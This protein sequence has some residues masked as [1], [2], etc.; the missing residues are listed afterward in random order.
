MITK[1]VAKTFAE[2]LGIALLLVPIAAFAVD[3]SPLT[4]EDAIAQA[5]REAPQITA[6]AAAFDAATAKAP[7]A[8]R[9]PDP[10][11]VA[12][13]DNL[14][15]NTADRFS[16]TRDFMTMRR[17]GVMQSFPNRAKRRL[18]STY[19]QQ[20]VLVA[21]AELRKTRFE[22]ARAA[23]EAWIASA[24]AEESLAR[25]R[26]LQ[27]DVE[28][29]ASAAR[30]ALASGR[31]SSA[32]ALAAQAVGARLDDRILTLEQ[33]A[34]MR[35]AELARWV[36]DGA[37]RPLAP[38]PTDLELGHSS[39]TLIAGITE[40]A[41]LAPT[42][43]RIAAARTE[44]ELARADK[45]P[46]WSA[47]LNYAKRGP[48]FSDMVSLE[49]RVGLPLFATHRQN[50]VIAEKLAMVRAEE[51]E[52]DADIRMQTAEI[53]AAFAEWRQGR[54]RLNHYAGELLPLAGDRVR[55]AIAGYAAGRTDLAATIDALS[56]EIEVQLEY[57]DLKGARARVWT[58]LHFL[59]DSGVSP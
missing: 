6:S 19:A 35:R 59:H 14:P 58:Y 25:L 20:E 4:L 28:L 10:E 54:A 55:A 21:G 7:S 18:E 51:A 57:V 33:D 52:R 29:Q 34:A 9:L 24:V 39:E 26:K 49:F 32:D 15:I 2:F 47:E 48:D 37:E 30:S 16:F 36:A 31:A 40:H 8:G 42:V 56:E 46:D 41:P 5:L 17:I 11:L 38:I 23:S 13:V 43:A 27:P 44:V 45:R 12:G 3:G 1:L 53:R 50:P 22:T